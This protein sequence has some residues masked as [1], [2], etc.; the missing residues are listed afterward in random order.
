[1]TE[2]NV[3]A[4]TRTDE[5]LVHV[6]ACLPIGKSN[7][8]MDLQKMQKN[9]IFRISQF[10]NTLTKDTKSSVY[11]FQLDEHWFT[12]DADLLHS[13][14]GI[15]PKDYAHP[16]EAPPAGDLVIDF[17]NSLGYP[18]VLKFVL[19]IPRHLVLQ[20]LWGVVTRTNI[21]YAELI[22]EEFIQAIKTFFS[23]AACLK[24][25]T[26][27]Y[28][29]Y[30]RPQ[31][32]VHITEDDYLLGNLKFVPKGGL[33]EV[34]GMPNLK[35]LITD[36][37][38]NSEYYKRYLEM[39]ARKPRQP[40]TMIDEEGGKKKKAT[41]AGKSKQRAL[42]KQSK[43]AKEKTSKPSPSKKTRKGKVMKVRKGKRTNY[44]VDEDDEEDQ[45]A[46]EPQ[47][48]DDEYNL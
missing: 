37:I 23:D 41:L 34:F 40:T 28:N 20:M 19:K 45:P 12:L 46:A 27:K 18:E 21:D 17:V 25:P 6:K 35:D 1:M 43:P 15:T 30:R 11:S 48:E 22:W 38:R 4:P 39:A 36:G 32:P 44:L 7:L 29:I 5:Q 14:L 2:K 26:K 33:D 47:M 3:P 42:T 24:V 13:A 16:F 9:P 10:W 8:L 31:S